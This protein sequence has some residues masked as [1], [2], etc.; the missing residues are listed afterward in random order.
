VSN[1]DEGDRGGVERL[2]EVE[3]LLTR[4]PEDVT[5]ALGLQAL[6]EHVGCAALA[7]D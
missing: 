7:Q 1:R 5:H 4:D 3:R 2:V 6:H